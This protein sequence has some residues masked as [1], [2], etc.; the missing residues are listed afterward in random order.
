VTCARNASH[1]YVLS[2]RPFPRAAGPGRP[3]R[4]AT[5]LGRGAL[6]DR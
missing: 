3:R 6:G 4:A 1:S 2:G 5:A